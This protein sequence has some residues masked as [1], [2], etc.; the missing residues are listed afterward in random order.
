MERKFQIPEMSI[1]EISKLYTGI[2]PIVRS[3][4]TSYY[5][6]DLSQEEL[7]H[8]AYTYLNKPWD[9]SRAVDY[10]NLSVITDIKML[11]RWS[12]YGNFK[13]SVAEVISQIPKRYLNKVVAFE[14][15]VGAIGMNGIY[16][17]E[18]N[19]GFHVSVV[20]L[21]QE[22]SDGMRPAAP[23]ECWPTKYSI[24]P[25]GMSESDFKEIFKIMYSVVE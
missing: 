3:C 20:R 14:I 7:S 6:R 22:K 9:L 13:P 16:R 19:A 24:C 11:H 17:A 4:G 18:L 5:L 25:L 10:S 15:I 12:Y 2:N 1:E 8:R 23:I 21:Y